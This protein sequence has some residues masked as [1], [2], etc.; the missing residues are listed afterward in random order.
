MGTR[1]MRVGFVGAGVCLLAAC[2]GEQV[3]LGQARLEAAD[4]EGSECADAGASETP[5]EPPKLPMAD[6]SLPPLVEVA[7]AGRC[8]V[9]IS[10]ELPVAQ[11]QTGC[12]PDA[13][14]S[15]HFFATT[16]VPSADGGAWIVGGHN[17]GS[18]SSPLTATHWLMRYGADGSLHCRAAV[19]SARPALAI[20]DGGSAWLAR[21]HA[22]GEPSDVQRY[23]GDCQAIDGPLAGLN[24]VRAIANVPGVG[25]AIVNGGDSQAVTLHDQSAQVLWTQPGSD[26]WR[27]SLATAGSNPLVL[28]ATQRRGA[29]YG[30]TV[31]ALDAQGS[32]R[33]QG[34]TQAHASLPGFNSYFAYGS[35]QQGNLVL[36]FTPS[37]LLGQIELL[38]F[39][40]VESIDA[41]GQTRWVLRLPSSGN[42]AAA[43][44]PS[45]EVYVA[46]PKS[47]NGSGQLSIAAIAQDGSTC[48]RL[49]YDSPG[50]LDKLAISPSGQL[51]YA[52][53]YEFG[54]F[55]PLP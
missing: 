46:V 55:G 21:T 45:G 53:Q 30:I 36:A 1:W 8:D 14:Q 34:S 11:R 41:S 48:S 12:G 17:V 43:V 51:W 10:A 42:V 13:T 33:W 4:C 25:V 15:C 24:E 54:R 3:W 47:R 28:G 2:S 35:D 7:V 44:A 27:V 18:D 6:P 16:L 19:G 9:P 23:D 37:D 29:A 22:F 26:D 20:D 31:R 40:D 38:Y 49:G 5:D 52:T 39:V 32:T 50:D